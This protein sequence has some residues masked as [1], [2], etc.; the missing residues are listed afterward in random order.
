MMNIKKMIER[1]EFADET[2][3]IDD[4]DPMA[5]QAELPDKPKNKG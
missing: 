3:K 1:N 2:K 5:F 4:F